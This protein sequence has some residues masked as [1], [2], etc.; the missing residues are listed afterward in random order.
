MKIESRA[1]GEDRSDGIQHIPRRIRQH[2]LCMI[3]HNDNEVPTD[4]QLIVI[5]PN[6][7]YMPQSYKFHDP[8]KKTLETHIFAFDL[9][10]ASQK[11]KERIE[12]DGTKDA[13][14]KKFLSLYEKLLAK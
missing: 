8:S 6:E 1:I 13:N 9:K 5:Y 2:D 3:L 11:N 4:F 7:H 14:R 10:E 12:R